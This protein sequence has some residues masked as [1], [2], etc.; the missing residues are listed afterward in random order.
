MIVAAATAVSMACG[1]YRHD[2]TIHNVIATG[3]DDRG[4]VVSLAEVIRL[5]WD[6]WGINPPHTNPK[7]WVERRGQVVR[8]G[9]VVTPVSHLLGDWPDAYA[10]QDGRGFVVTNGGDGCRLVT[11]TGGVTDCPFEANDKRVV[12]FLPRSERLLLAGKPQ[13]PGSDAGYTLYTL[14]LNPAFDLKNSALR[15]LDD[16][17]LELPYNAPAG[18]G[19]RD[20]SYRALAADETAWVVACPRGLWLVSRRAEPA[21]LISYDDTVAEPRIAY[22]PRP[23]DD[24]RT[25]HQT[26]GLAWSPDASRI[27]YCPDVDKKAVIITA[28]TRQV[29]PVGMCLGGAAWS[30]AGRTIT[31]TRAGMIADQI[32]VQ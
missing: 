22:D 3:W 27:Y 12:Y 23:E 10:R 20:A 4:G 21:L 1:T 17:F 5:R 14:D 11:L 18:L 13:R 9:T 26:Y 29:Q 30:P 16:A 28:A 8:Q 32:V 19:C 15:V 25:F 2:K 24:Q 7:T 6:F 31:G